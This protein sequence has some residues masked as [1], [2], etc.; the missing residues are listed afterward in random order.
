VIPIGLLLCGTA[1]ASGLALYA[2]RLREWGLAV[3]MVLITVLALAAAWVAFRCLGHDCPFD[4]R[5]G[6]DSRELRAR[7]NDHD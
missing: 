7:G 6:L 1:F 2:L 3:F 5:A 4:A